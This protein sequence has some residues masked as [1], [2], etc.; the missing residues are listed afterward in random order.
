MPPPLPRQGAVVQY[1]LYWDGHPLC[2]RVSLDSL[3]GAEVLP[4][5]PGL[6]LFTLKQY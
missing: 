4:T 5:E 1:R 3:A 2:K 6:S